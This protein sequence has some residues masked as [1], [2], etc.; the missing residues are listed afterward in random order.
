MQQLVSTWPN[1]AYNIKE[2][3]FRKGLYSILSI[4]NLMVNTDQSVQFTWTYMWRDLGFDSTFTKTVTVTPVTEGY[5]VNQITVSKLDKLEETC[6]RGE[7]DAC[8]Q[9]NMDELMGIHGI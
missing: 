1:D 5:K 2:R 4:D 3:H 9:A 7:W 6:F 8:C